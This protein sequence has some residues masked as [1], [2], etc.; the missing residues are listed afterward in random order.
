MGIQELIGLQLATTESME[1]TV[2]T[3]VAVTAWMEKYV[4]LKTVPV[5]LVLVD[6]KEK[7]AIK[8]R[9]LY[10]TKC[11]ICNFH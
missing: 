10:K 3:I 5:R 7:S 1:K 2:S 6:S 4:I 9:G 8:V 11:L